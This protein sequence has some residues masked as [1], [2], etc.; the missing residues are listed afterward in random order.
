[1]KG[2]SGQRPRPGPPR[3]LEDSFQIKRVTAHLGDS[4][5]VEYKLDESFFRDCFLLLRFPTT[6]R[7][8]FLLGVVLS[9]EVASGWAKA[10]ALHAQG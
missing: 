5:T 4:E 3:D 10:M 2:F 1:M 6:L 8:R 9:D 7:I